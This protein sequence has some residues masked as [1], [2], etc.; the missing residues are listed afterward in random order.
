MQI[1]YKSQDTLRLEPITSLTTPLHIDS[2]LLKDKSNSTKEF[3][4]LNNYQTA[5]LEKENRLELLQTLQEI[6]YDGINPKYFELNKIKDLVENWENSTDSLKIQADITFTRAFEQLTQVLFNG[7]LD[8]RKIYNDWDLEY[9]QINTAKTLILVLDNNAVS[10]A[11]DSIRPVHPQYHRYRE[12]LKQ[13]YTKQT[14]SLKPID[15]LMVVNQNY[16]A[17]LAIKSHMK[18]LS[19]L[20]DTLSIDTNYSPGFDQFLRDFQIQN[21]ITPSNTINS[22]TLAV[23]DKQRQS[24]YQKLMVNLER[25]RWFPRRYGKDYILVNIPDF[26]LVSVMGKDTIQKHNVI[27]GTPSRKTPILSSTLT[28]LVLNP[29]W[30]VPPTILKNDI[31]PKAKRNPGY[32]ASQNFTIYQ[33]STGKTV[34][35][36]QWDPN[37]YNSYRYVQK[38]GKGNTLGRI[39]FMFLNNHS[40]YLHDTPNKNNFN[41]Q[42]RDISSGCV[43]V[44]DPFELA[45]FI[46]QVQDNDLNKQDIDKIIASEKTTNIS[47]QK[48]PI[49]VYLLYWTLN[50]NEDLSFENIQDIYKYD[51]NLFTK[52]TN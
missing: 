2:L 12:K 42:F 3:Y 50:L 14:D 47:V 45:E 41:K 13:Y 17:L 7:I 9:H 40:V 48:N 25:F 51:T 29:T 5:W 18:F 1:V 34:T 16:D 26:T 46:L 22:N 52:L 23:L 8:P 20:P 38:G 15:T 43:R 35:P 36:E 19:I 33:N 30:T 4:Q 28:T 32:F 10:Q 24:L 37:K 27:V 11:F 49:G 21:K 44:Q 6:H 39:K 31:V